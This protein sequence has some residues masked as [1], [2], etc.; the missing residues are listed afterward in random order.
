[1]VE[2]LA[3]AGDSLLDP[4][5]RTR[6]LF[7][8]TRDGIRSRLDRFGSWSRSRSGVGAGSSS[9]PT[10]EHIQPPDELST[11]RQQYESTPLLSAPIDQMSDDVLADGRRVVADDDRTQ[12]FLAGWVESC[13][14]VAGE[15]HRDIIEL[16]DLWNKCYDI[17]G[18]APSEN[19][20][21]VERPDAI[22]ALKMIPPATLSYHTRPQSS[23]LVRPED[24]DRYDV[25]TTPR[26]TAAA[27]TQYADDASRRWTDESGQE[28]DPIHL[29]AEQVT[30]G[31]RNPEVG[32]VA[33]S[34]AIATVSADVERQT[35]YFEHD[36]TA[37]ES[38]AWG[39]WFA[40]F[41]P[42]VLDDEIIEFDEGA[43]DDFESELEGVEPGG[44]VTHDGKI[45]L[46]NMPGELADILDRY[47]YQTDYILS[48]MPAPKFMTGFA[49]NLNRD[50]ADDQREAH[51]QRVALRKER[52]SR[53]FSPVLQR[54][55][56][57]F[58]H[59]PSGVRL[60]LEPEE[61]GSPILSL[62]PEEIESIERLANAIDTVSGAADASTLVEEDALLDL[63]LQLPEG[64]GVPT[65]AATASGVNEA[66][67]AVQEQFARLQEAAAAGDGES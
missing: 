51:E 5:P 24:D 49:D 60:L 20:P 39:Q 66:D 17:Y 41:E 63:V 1:V 47:E 10:P 61:S 9:R 43:Q 38:L 8:G 50:I 31:V 28:L 62:S 59:D 14:I 37:V 64:V 29:D 55:A 45:N 42:I 35:D 15:P 46:E 27:Y 2:T 11:Y 33:G 18:V 44:I 40:G 53:T 16:L 54:V 3:H 6:S 7:D 22:A 4:D 57:Q 12:E 67:P 36:A 30:R 58:G 56:E 48:A 25:E 23:M 26:D 13:A 52:I 19:V 21:A 65:D 32:G 34:S